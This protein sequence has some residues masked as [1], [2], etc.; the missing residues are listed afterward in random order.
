MYKYRKQL[1]TGA[2][3]VLA[4]YIILLILLDASGQMRNSDGLLD[5]LAAFPLWLIPVLCLLQVGAGLFRFWEW[6]YY[7][8]VIGARDKISIKDSAIIFTSAFTMVVS[9]GKVAEVLKSVFLKMKTGIAVWRSAPVVV[10]ERV[11]DGLAVV[12]TL[13]AVLLIAPGALVM[14]EYGDISRGVLY[15]ASVLLFGGL[16]AVQIKPLAYFILDR[17]IKNLPLINRLHEPLT[18]FYESSREVFLIRHVTPTTIMGLGVYACSTIGFV[19]ILLGFGVP[20]SGDLVLQA[21]FIVGVASAVGAFSFVPNGAG[22]T[23]ITNYAMLMA[24]VAPTA[25]TLTAGVVAAAALLQG[26]FHKWFR[27]LVGA[28]VAYIY[29]KRLFTAELDAAIESMQ[30]E[31]RGGAMVELQRSA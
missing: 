27:V 20:M 4:T 11:V 10:A 29:R 24:L 2:V 12:I 26:F 28:G 13:T 9:P 7:L 30:D 25:P 8:G 5:A 17:I 14:G 3:I 16:I 15:T 31:E 19:L 6:H 1:A 22:V 21:A 18:E 23:E